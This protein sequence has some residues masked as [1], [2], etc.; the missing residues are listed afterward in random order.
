MLRQASQAT[1]YSLLLTALSI[2]SCGSTST[3]TNTASETGGATGT[4]PG[5]GGTSSAGGSTS[6]GT[7]SFIGV[8][9]FTSGSQTPTCTGLTV[10]ATTLTNSTVSITA[11]TTA[12]LIAVLESTCTLHF[13]VSGTAANV[14]TG[15][16]CTESGTIEGEAYTETDTYTSLVITT[17][18]GQNAHVSGAYNAVL[19]VAGSSYDCTVSITGDMQKQ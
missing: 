1:K 14:E 3:T 10:N 8:W 13:D 19:N 18:D 17:T 7:S 15:Q 6:T 12:P 9:Q 16:I 5:T 11:G 2:V 4:N